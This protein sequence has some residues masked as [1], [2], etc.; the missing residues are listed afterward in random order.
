MSEEEAG[1]GHMAWGIWVPK[2]PN[3]RCQWPD[4]IKVRA[5]ERARGGETIAAI[6]REISANESLVAQWVKDAEG[7]A[8]ARKGAPEFVEVLA[9]DTSARTGAVDHCSIR[10]GDVELSVP[11]GYP[12]AHLTEILRAVRAAR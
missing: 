10:L 4:E 2:R 11:P 9:G 5:V 3:G 1:S 7:P 12:G 6:A 8:K